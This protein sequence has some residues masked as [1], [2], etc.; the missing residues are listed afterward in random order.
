M[1]QVQFSAGPLVPPG[2]ST[3]TSVALAKDERERPT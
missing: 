2:Q 3:G 1:P